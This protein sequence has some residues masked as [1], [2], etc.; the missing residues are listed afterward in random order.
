MWQK[1]IRF[2]KHKDLVFF[3]CS[4]TQVGSAGSRKR[5]WYCL[6]LSA[7][8]SKVKRAGSR[9]ETGTV[10]PVVGYVEFSGET[11][12]FKCQICV[13]MVLLDLDSRSCFIFLLT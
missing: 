7:H 8:H 3:N 10:P 1:E 11:T 4:V 2:Y 12:E 13:F 6:L 5:N 9:R